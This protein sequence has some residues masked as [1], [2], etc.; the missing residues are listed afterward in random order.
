MQSQIFSENRRG[1]PPI[2]EIAPDVMMTSISKTAQDVGTTRAIPLS[3]PK[4]PWTP[5]ADVSLPPHTA[6]GAPWNPSFPAAALP[7]ADVE[8]GVA[9]SQPQRGAP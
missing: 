3:L 1:K 6:P 4:I 8:R 2:V 9:S 7:W 5:V